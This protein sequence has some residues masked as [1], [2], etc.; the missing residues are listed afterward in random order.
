MNI[1]LKIKD[2]DQELLQIASN[3]YWGMCCPHTDNKDI[4]FQAI[5]DILG[6]QKPDEVGLSNRAIDEM[7]IKNSN[8]F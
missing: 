3:C 2:V 6:I 1:I 5:L 7:I 8:K 4:Y